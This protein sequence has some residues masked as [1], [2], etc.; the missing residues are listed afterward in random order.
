MFNPWKDLQ[1][2]VA[3]P[4]LQVGVVSA[5]DEGV[6][7]VDLPGGGQVRARGVASVSQTVFLRGDVIEGV[8][9]DAGPIE[10]IDL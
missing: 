8:A 6:A 10:I 4:A 7:T 2:L 9:P 5:V 1:S 3:G